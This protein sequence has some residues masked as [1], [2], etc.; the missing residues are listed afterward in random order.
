MKDNRIKIISITLLL[1]FFIVGEVFGGSAHI[2][3]A[4]DGQGQDANISQVAAR[5]PYFVFFDTHGNFIEA[6]QNPAKDKS[7]GAG[8]AAAEF[9]AERG[10]KTVVAESFGSKMA[11][12]LSENHIEYFEKK[13][14]AHVV[15]QTMYKK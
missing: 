6:V 2:A 1:L 11:Q 4:V 12:A 3:A 14:V 5:A 8:S 7:G 9:L 15:V 10:V 13:G